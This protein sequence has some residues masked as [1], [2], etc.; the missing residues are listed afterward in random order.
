MQAISRFF[1]WFGHQR[2]NAIFHWTRKRKQAEWLL[3]VN[4]LNKQNWKNNKV[5]NIL[6]KLL[7]GKKIQTHMQKES[8]NNC[9][10]E[11]KLKSGMDPHS[12]W[13]CSIKI[14][15]EWFFFHFHYSSCILQRDSKWVICIWKNHGVWNYKMIQGLDICTLRY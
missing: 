4:I 8:T 15:T 2:N 10:K 11:S 13:A 9:S 7:I 14:N 6:G 5:T 3:G 1:W 12:F